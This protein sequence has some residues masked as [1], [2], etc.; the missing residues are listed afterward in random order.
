MKIAAQRRLASL[1]GLLLLALVVSAVG[2]QAAQAV[3]ATNTGGASGTVAVTPALAATQ[4]RGG[5]DASS[6]IAPQQQGPAAAQLQANGGR[7]PGEAHVLAASPGMSTSSTIAW[8][9][10]GTAAA[11][12]IVLIAVLVPTRRRRQAGERPS[13]AYCAEHPDDALCMTA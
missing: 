9:I 13:K 11:V 6:F 1:A 12:V 4:G 5:F 7:L 3:L 8:I 2:V 10:G